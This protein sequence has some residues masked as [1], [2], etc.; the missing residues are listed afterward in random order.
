LIPLGKIAGVDA[1]AITNSF[2]SR[3]RQSFWGQVFNGVPAVQITRG[4]AYAM[5][6]LITVLVVGF[7]IAGIASIP[8]I[9]RKRRRRQ[10]AGR[11]LALDD[12][13][14]E[15]KRKAIESIFVEHGAAGLKRARQLLA[16]EEKLKYALKTPGRFYGGGVG[17]P[18]TE[19]RPERM[20]HAGINHVVPEPLG[21]LFVERLVR[22]KDSELTLDPDIKALL[23]TYIEQTSGS[24]VEAGREA[25]E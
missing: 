10:V 9:W 22:Y 8:G 12:P 3:D 13:E 11:L 14:Q 21:P 4:I 25:A 1:I 15:K 20:V 24:D 19:V 23:D 17:Y 5:L 6:A 16:N 7:S 18:P 2:E